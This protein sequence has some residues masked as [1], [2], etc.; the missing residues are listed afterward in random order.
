MFPHFSMLH[1]T[2]FLP[3]LLLPLL[4]L[5]SAS[6]RAPNVLLIV[7][8]D[9]GYADLSST[10][11]TTISTPNIDS[12]RTMFTQF[13]ASAP[14]CTPSR[15]ALM[16]G[17]LPQRSGVYSGLKPPCFRDKTVAQLLKDSPSNYT[18]AMI[19]KWHLGH[20]SSTTPT[21]PNC[22]PGSSRQGFD[23]FF[24]LPYSHEEGY[25]GP[26]PEGVVFP[27]VPLY[28]NGQIVEQPFVESDLTTRYANVTEY[29][30]EALSP[31]SKAGSIPVPSTLD[32]I[33]ASE[34]SSSIDVEGDR[35]WFIHLGFENPHVPL[36]VSE[37]YKENF[38]PSKRGD[39]GDSVTE[40]DAIIGS[41][42]STL[43]STSQLSNTLIIFL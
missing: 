28:A 21:S 41:L 39:Y 17:R 12:L 4:P 2:S 16:S 3:F 7:A 29:L 26:S 40:M 24:G 32:P 36:F 18:T 37:G 6:S 20:H 8:D 15:A 14:I 13:Y 19:G 42:L 31:G 38:E 1:I 30:I 27:P 25:P 43:S 10:G 11:S 23:F 5:S 33:T 22:L 9:L 35:P 34:L